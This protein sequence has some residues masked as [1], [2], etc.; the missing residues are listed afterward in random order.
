MLKAISISSP[1]ILAS[2]PVT[3]SPVS[4]EVAETIMWPGS[5]S[6][7]GLMCKRLMWA[8]SRAKMSAV[9]HAFRSEA[10]STTVCVV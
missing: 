8:A 2:N 9:L 1:S 5:N 7:P 4:A 6:E 10:V 3:S